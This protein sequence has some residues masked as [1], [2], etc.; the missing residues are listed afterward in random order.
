MGYIRNILSKPS[1]I[2]LLILIFLLALFT[3]LSLPGLWEGFGFVFDLDGNFTIAP[4]VSILNGRLVL[5]FIVIGV[6]ILMINGEFDLSVGPMMVMG[7]FVFGTLLVGGTSIAQFQLTDN[8]SLFGPFAIDNGLFPVLALVIAI[9][10]TTA[11]GI[12][13]G[14]IVTSFK[15]PSFITTLGTLFIFLWLVSLYGNA[16]P[17]NV[18]SSTLEARGTSTLLFDIFSIQLR[19]I[20]WVQDLVI[21]INSNW[22][23]ATSS[24]SRFEIIQQ[25]SAWGLNLRVTIFWL[26]GLVILMQFVM[27]RTRFGNRI[28]AVGGNAEAARNQGINV[29]RAKISTFALTGMFSGIAG[30]M[31]FSASKSVQA[32]SGTEQELFAIAAAVIGGTLLTG[33]FGSVMG[34]FLGVLILQ[35]LNSG[36]IRLSTPL[37]E[38]FVNDIPAIGP[39]IVRLTASDNFV[40]VV[41]I[42]IVG[43][44]V[45]NTFIRRRL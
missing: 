30:V 12:F 15:I 1:G 38:S 9:A 45:L 42:A 22:D 20:P 33:G 27:T 29:R 8:F 2:P 10:A 23:P 25:Q 31:L 16:S 36:A 18:A 11:M 39:I 21:A 17:F 7:A 19:N 4:L 34:G 44:A 37:G 32:S 24:L 6:V 35:T 41:G 5:G 26:I 28:Y 3:F 43:A 13:N 14:F 40:A